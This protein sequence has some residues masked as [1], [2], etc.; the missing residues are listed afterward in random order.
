MQEYAS[1]VKMN[2]CSE[3]A[4]SCNF[5]SALSSWVFTIILSILLIY[6]PVLSLE[7]TRKSLDHH[8]VPLRMRSR[9]L[10][11]PTQVPC[12]GSGVLQSSIRHF[13]G[14]WG[15]LRCADQTLLACT[16][17]G[18]HKGVPGRVGWPGRRQ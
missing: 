13:C 1:G 8:F 7:L 18:W 16:S 14:T 9:V 4:S 5:Y 6:S 2:T 17:V 11:G 3:V 10:T 15:R 12:S